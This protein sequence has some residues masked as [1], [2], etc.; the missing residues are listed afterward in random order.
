[1]KIKY[2]TWVIVTKQS[3]IMFGTSSGNLTDELQ[4]ALFFSDAVLAEREL[5]KYDD[6]ENFDIRKIIVEC[7]L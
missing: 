1:M 2:N 7:E 6:P 3:P 5:E 4:E